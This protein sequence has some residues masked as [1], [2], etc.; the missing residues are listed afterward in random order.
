MNS[1]INKNIFNRVLFFITGLFIMSIGVAL[2][3]KASLGVSPISCV[4][5][6][7]SME[8][9]LTLGELVIIQ[10][11]LLIIM[12]IIL[13]RRKYRLFQL[14]QLPAVFVFGF[15]IDLSLLLLS[16]I[17]TSFYLQKIILCVLGCA[18]LAFGIFLIVKAGITYMPGEGLAMAIIEVFHTDFGK[19]KIGIDSSMVILGVISSYAILHRLE[20][21]REGTVLSALLVGYL[22]R[23]YSSRLAVFDKWLEKDNEEK[24]AV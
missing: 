21:I 3:V 11:I 23:F 5:Y 22:I 6:I 12:Q 7:F 1:R 15:F 8:F 2:S 13:L 20:G 16:D 17:D 24:T 10:N 14:V 4:P 18:V 19:T 9:P